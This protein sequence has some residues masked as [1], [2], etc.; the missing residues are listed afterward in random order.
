MHVKRMSPFDVQSQYPHEQQKASRQTIEDEFQPSGNSARAAPEYDHEVHGNHRDFPHH[1]KQEKV[2]GREDDKHGAFDQKD[3]HH[4]RP[5]MR[6]DRRPRTE[7]AKGREKSREQYQENADAIDSDRILNVERRHPL[8]YVPRTAS[9]LRL[10]Q[11]RTRESGR[12]RNPAACTR[13][14]FAEPTARCERM[15]GPRFQRR[16]RR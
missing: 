10:G 2:Q 8:H 13:A 12:A 6:G 4:E 9:P 1:E 7:Y 14:Q 3:Q 5:H 16:E 11:T 15:A